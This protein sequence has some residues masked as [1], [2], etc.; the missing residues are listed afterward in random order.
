[1]MVNK[2]WLVFPV[3]IAVG[4]GSLLIHDKVYARQETKPKFGKN[5][6]V[7]TF[8]NSKEEL[9]GWMHMIKTSLGVDCDYCHN[10]D[11]FASDAKPPK[12]VA[13]VMIKMLL[14]IRKDY[15]SFPN[16]PQPTCYTCH[17]GH[18]KPTNEPAGGFP[19][20]ND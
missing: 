11:N 19:N 4:L 16:A 2:S 13:R 18:K 5:L 6:Q 7:L 15:F 9:K 8:I 14:Q 3:L 20:G 12:R 17:Q 10:T 1:M